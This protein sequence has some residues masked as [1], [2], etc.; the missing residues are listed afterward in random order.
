VV[1][2]DQDIKGVQGHRIAQE[3]PLEVWAKPL[4]DG[5]IAVGLMN[6][7]ESVNSI[8]L[9]FKNI[10]VQ[11]A[12]KVRDLWQGKDLGSFSGSYTAAVP[13]HGASLIRVR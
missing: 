11:G 12:A 10:G 4:A 13:R 1:A 6:R 2:V 7:G 9:S 5:S 3:G 8:T